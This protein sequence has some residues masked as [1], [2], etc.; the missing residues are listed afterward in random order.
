MFIIYDTADH[1]DFWESNTRESDSQ[2]VFVDLSLIFRDACISRGRV[3]CD[4]FVI[5]H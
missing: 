5:R 1:C 2:P 3:V 4:F